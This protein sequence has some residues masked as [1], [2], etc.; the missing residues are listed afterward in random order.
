MYIIFKLRNYLINDFLIMLLQYLLQKL[1]TGDSRSINLNAIPGKLATRFDIADFLDID[2]LLIDDFFKKLFNQW[3]FKFKVDLW[4]I[5]IDKDLEQKQDS[6]FWDSTSGKISKKK[7]WILLKRL[8]TIIASEE[9]EFQ[10][11]GVRSFWFGYPLLVKKIPKDFGADKI[12]V[13]PLFIRKL[14]IE[15]L[16]SSKYT[17]Q[18]SRDDEMWF[19]LNEVLLWS[20]ETN[21]K[22][23]VK[24]I[25]EDAMDDW[26]LSQEELLESLNWLLSQ[27]WSSE[28]YN[29]LKDIQKIPWS[30][31]EVE[32][33]YQKEW[34]EKPTVFW[35]WVFGLYRTL[36]QKIIEDTKKIPIDI[37]DSLNDDQEFDFEHPYGSVSTD[38]SQ[39]IVLDNLSE[40]EGMVIQWPPWTWKSQTITAIITN[41]LD[42]NKKCLVVCEKRTALEVIKNNLSK[43]DLWDMCALIEDVHTARKDIVEL[44]RNKQEHG[45]WISWFR[46][47]EYGTILSEVNAVVSKFN[48][49]RDLLK[50]DY[51]NNTDWKSLVGKYLL[52]SKNIDE[53]IIDNL[54]DNISDYIEDQG[55][56]N[57]SAI[58]KTIKSWEEL[59]F[60]WAKISFLNDL[61]LSIFTESISYIACKTQF[62]KFYKQMRDLKKE[63]EITTNKFESI[64]ETSR[65]TYEES[66]KYNDNI[67]FRYFHNNEQWDIIKSL[68]KNYQIVWS[69]AWLQLVNN[70]VQ[71]HSVGSYKSGDD[72]YGIHLNPQWIKKVIDLLE[73]DINNQ[74]LFNVSVDEYY[75]SFV[76]K[77]NEI[78]TSILAIKESIDWLIVKYSHAEQLWSFHYFKHNLLWLFSQKHKEIH[79][80]HELI[81][82][83]YILCQKIIKE[84]GFKNLYLQIKPFN[85]YETLISIKD[86]LAKIE[87]ICL[88]C[89]LNIINWS[90]LKNIVFDQD[91]ESKWLE[92]NKTIQST[93][94][95]LSDYFVSTNVYQLKSLSNINDQLNFYQSI[96][97]KLENEKDNL[98]KFYD[99]ICFYEALP[100]GQKVIID[101][102]IKTWT[103]QWNVFF[104][105]VW[106]KGLLLRNDT[107]LLPKNDND[108]LKLYGLV[109]DFKDHQVKWIKYKRKEMAENSMAQLKSKWITIQSLYNKRWAPWERRNSLRR[110]VATDFELFTNIFPVVLVSPQVCSSILP[111]EKDL[112]DIVLFDEASQI[113]LEDV[114]SAMY[115]GK[116]KIICW[117]QH[118]MP[119]SNFFAWS[120]ILLEAS[121]DEVEESDDEIKFT[122]SDMD[123]Q[124]A[125]S[126]S[127]LDYAQK[128][129]Y[130]QYMLKV[131]YRSEH[132]ILIDF[133][134][135]A[136]YWWRLQAL[137]NK[138]D[139]KPIS[140][141]E[142]DGEL[143]KWVN[144]KEAIKVIKLLQEILTDENIS[145][146]YNWVIPTVGIA[147]FN[148]Y[149][150]NYIWDLIQKI[151]Y[152]NSLPDLAD[153]LDQVNLFVKNL[154][155]IQG[156]ERDI[157]IISTTFAKKNDG[158][159]AQNYWPIN[160]SKWYRLLNVMITRAKKEVYLVTSI[161]SEI[162]TQ[163][164]ERLKNSMWET[165]HWWSLLHAYINYCKAVH[166]S[167]EPL[168]LSILNKIRWWEI[169]KEQEDWMTESPFE[170]EVLS[171]LSEIIDPS[172]I[173]LQH[174]VWWFRIDMI[175]LSKK[176]NKPLIAIECD[177]ATYHSGDT[178]YCNDIFRQSILEWMWFIFHRI[179]SSN[180][181]RDRQSEEKK[182]RMFLEG[183]DELS[184]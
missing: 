93:N 121:D 64:I 89:S 133:S 166:E 99:R 130:F 135:H 88:E 47:N 57:Y 84:S 153:K 148:M 30:K 152:E 40:R 17:Y 3:A 127:L 73:K 10:E 174:K 172:R 95:L 143:H 108:I 44:V 163:F 161:P 83:Q 147:T 116:Q 107:N 111:L 157:I 96:L 180:R 82:N 85:K 34:L 66:L 35:W 52:K 120:N 39:Q 141:Y 87:S 181:W 91:I 131:H 6:L 7:R 128:K 9:D 146:K 115:R 42:N 23:L 98:E 117:D 5:D 155:T 183:L 105:I 144:E 151:K 74:Q 164:E 61:K 168:R 94:Q 59:F 50:K 69:E 114:M 182:L 22:V 113:R 75:A 11:H 24:Q 173:K 110:I 19:G 97:D 45:F 119:P 139:Y 170:E 13:A 38:P 48:L 2:P 33:F 60:P 55:Y 36:K 177:G 124:L 179:R 158:K 150:R 70:I 123:T 79:K 101:E 165:K 171:S 102:L 12:M 125:N 178:A 41:A 136:F 132:P 129:W 145:K 176:T 8:N 175:I 142:V 18:I 134:N 37:D 43:I 1:K 65:R 140:F 104:E 20:L 103:K 29:K 90:L 27:C 4:S 72:L 53:G 25:W 51:F 109:K 32:E 86:Q 21:D 77:V 76:M 58:V 100:D 16:K 46:W 159:F 26:V 167:N 80:Q 122:W 63:S 162:Y 160:Q 106:L 49:Q 118:Q 28:V 14:T 31:K 92:I 56:E 81:Y 137:P 78:V 156:D 154:D 62:D 149:Q 169:N 68:I 126:E 54:Y 184:N 71:S 138:L 67:N 112:F 15:R